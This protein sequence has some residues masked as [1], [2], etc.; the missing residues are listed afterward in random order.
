[1]IHS[2]ATLPEGYLTTLVAAGFG[3]DTESETLLRTALS[4]SH[5]QVRT[6]A[7]RGLLRRERITS[8]EWESQ[9]RDRDSSVRREALN[10]AGHRASNPLSDEVFLGALQDNDALVV[11]AAIFAAGERRILAARQTI[12]DIARHHEDARCREIAVVALAQIGE[13]TS[14]PVIIRTLSDKPTVRRR[15]VVALSGFEGD[16]VEAALDE[17]SHD[18]DWQVRSAVERLRRVDSVDE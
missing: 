1:M 4:H 8:G 16:E 7:L 13:P 15:T 5:P 2:D 14:L 3:N 6:L 17:A 18:R 11:E 10:E 12:E 9:V